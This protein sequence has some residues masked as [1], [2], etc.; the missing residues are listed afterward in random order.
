MKEFFENL[1]SKI[2]EAVKNDIKPILKKVGDEK[3][4]AVALVTDSD[5]ITLYLVLNT[6]EYMQKTDENYIRKFQDSWSEEII[7]DI[8]EGSRYLTKWIPAEWGYSNGKESAF[9]KISEALFK[10]E[11]D[12]EEYGEHQ[13]EFFQTVTSAF[14]RIV[15]EKAFG[16]DSDKITYF[17]SISD[18]ERTP[19]I[20]NE[21][22]KVLNSEG[23]YQTF[24]ERTGIYG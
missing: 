7:K 12:L 19:E 18:D 22:A 3:I 23:V 21:S 16:K 9:V 8:R 5:C 10:K 1:E 15:D 14:K 6:Y 11:M 4:Y 13:E 20:E 17:I 24:L 2:Y